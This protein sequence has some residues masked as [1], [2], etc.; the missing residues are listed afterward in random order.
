MRRGFGRI[1][2]LV[3]TKLCPRPSRRA[4]R[5]PECTVFE[6][7]A[8]ESARNPDPDLDPGGCLRN[9]PFEDS[10]DF[11]ESCTRLALRE[12][13]FPGTQAAS[14]P[15]RRPGTL[16][17]AR[18]VRLKPISSKTERSRRSGHS[19]LGSNSVA[20]P[21][22]GSRPS[23]DPV[24]VD[25]RPASRRARTTSTTRGRSFGSSRRARRHAGTSS[26]RRPIRSSRAAAIPTPSTSV[27]V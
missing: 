6:P 7:I 1:S 4:F 27:G 17:R 21:Q 12:R 18:T 2:I 22:L 13:L 10:H 20:T 19:G 24:A 16:R 11:F 25:Q 14:G 3:R 5:A 9:P 15:P 26:T 8:T 23:P